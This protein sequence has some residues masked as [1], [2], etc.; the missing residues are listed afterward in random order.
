MTGTLEAVADRPEN[1]ILEAHKIFLK[2][3]KIPPNVSVLNEMAI[4]RFES[5]GFPHSKHEMF[6]FVNTRGVADTVFEAV[7]GESVEKGSLGIYKGFEK[8]CVTLVDGQ[9]RP[10]LSDVSACGEGLQITPL[11]QAFSDPSIEEYL[12]K[13]LDN[14][15]DAF[16]AIN[17]SFFGQ[18]VK[19]GV[20]AK[21]A[22]PVPLQVLYVSTG[23]TGLPLTSW[24]RVLFEVKSLGEIKTVIRFTGVNGNYFVNAVQDVILEDGSGMTYTQV[25]E[26]V[27]DAFHFSKTRLNLGRDS[28]FDGVNAS[29]GSK[30]ARHHYEAHLQGEGAEL[31]LNG[32]NVL[33]NEEQVHYYIRVTHEAPRCISNMHFKSIVN[34]RARSSVDGTVVVEKD[35]QLTQSDQLINNLILG[36]D[37]HADSKPNLI[38]NA[39][40]VKCTHGNTVGQLD[41]E[42]LFYLKTRGLSESV[43]K[44]LLTQSFATS[45]VETVPF[46]SVRKDLEDTLLKKLE[47]HND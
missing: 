33:V 47:V 13:T 16:A 2:N 37:A 27:K 40:D 5:L 4:R 10:E 43:S 9:F 18:G 45:I 21:A 15:N 11:D 41:E 28:R 14:E 38:I 20:Q 25:Q 3:S 32:I 31:C 34:N 46:D 29:S 42:Q 19:I 26:D 24:P 44:T 17:G 36:D 35:A 22:I 12:K 39:D 7:S 6:T 1:K 8:S 30:L 23:S